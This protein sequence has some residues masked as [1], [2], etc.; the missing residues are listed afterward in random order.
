[1]PHRDTV[2]GRFGLELQG[3]SARH[4]GSWHYTASTL[5][6]VASDPG[7]SSSPATCSSPMRKSSRDPRG[8]PC[9]PDAVENKR[10]TEDPAL[11]FQ[12]S[13]FAA[14]AER[15]HD[16]DSPIQA[17]TVADQVLPFPHGDLAAIAARFAPYVRARRKVRLRLSL[18]RLL[19]PHPCIQ[20]HAS[21][22]RTR[23]H[24]PR[25]DGAHAA[26]S[27]AQLEGELWRSKDAP[28][29]YACSGHTNRT[30]RV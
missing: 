5:H 8:L 15:R 12:A 30:S 7:Q 16:L 24:S 27:T 4:H 1:M 25:L 11:A 17:F 29:P 19:K 20:D 28:I 18:T 9:Q 13:M 22:G 6:G 2:V 10:T 21:T 3:R 26:F 14:G 23:R